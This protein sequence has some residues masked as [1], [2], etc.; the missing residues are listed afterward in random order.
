MNASSFGAVLGETTTL[1]RLIWDRGP[2]D[3][4]YRLRAAAYQAGMD[5]IPIRDREAH[6]AETHL[7]GMYVAATETRGRGPLIDMVR[8]LMQETATKVLSESALRRLARRIDAVRY[9]DAALFALDHDGGH[10]IEVERGVREL[11][12]L[13]G[14][15]TWA[16]YA[17][18]R[19]EV[20][21][22]LTVFAQE[23]P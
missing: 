19:D 9:L 6:F 2:D 21:R 23:K 20:L 18:K 3:D 1:V 7:S 14:A 8:H 13:S 15:D 4:L 16:A 22:W 10:G 17:A 12:T 5:G 11:W